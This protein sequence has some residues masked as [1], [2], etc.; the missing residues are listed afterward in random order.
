MC[1]PGLGDAGRRG[2]P[3]RLNVSFTVEGKLFAQEEVFGCERG[4]RAQTET[5]ITQGIDEKRQQRASKLYEV[6]G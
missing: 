2:G 5:D 1:W 4:G 6:M 3:P